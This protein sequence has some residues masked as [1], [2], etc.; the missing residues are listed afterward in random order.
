MIDSH[1]HLADD[2]FV[3][4]LEATVAR[5]VAAGV[6]G[7]L[8]IVDA[9]NA[10]ERS[11]AA[12]LERLWEEL[13]FGV[14]IHPHQAGPWAGRTEAALETVRT[15]L[16]DLPAARAVGET[17]LDFHYD[18][19]PREVQGEL[20]AA[21]VALALERDLPVVVHAREADD[22]ALAVLKE[23]GQ[24]RVRGVMHCFTGDRAF[25]RR[26]LDLGLHI[27]LAGIVT[28]PKADA[29]REVARFVP[30]DRLLVETD[31]PYLAP[32]PHRGNRNEP[33]WV[34]TVAARVAEARGLGVPELAAQITENY[35]GLFRP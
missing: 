9:A 2:A 16:A 15:A 3:P 33:A 1:C 26:A 27:S 32:V 17:G 14:G 29:L 25:A 5:A 12:A 8:C 10:V 30:A 35:R 22:A 11:R 6:T 20:F 34:I 21:Q 18:F 19:S 7:A 4:D 28:F 24:G 23:A 31:S 13:R